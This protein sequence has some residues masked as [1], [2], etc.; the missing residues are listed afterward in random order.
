[1]N[2]IYKVKYYQLAMLR[3]QGYNTN[4]EDELNYFKHFEEKG[5]LEEFIE[6]NHVLSRRYISKLN[7]EPKYCYY[8]TEKVSKADVTA[9][10]KEVGN[11]KVIILISKSGITPVALDELIDLTSKSYRFVTFK[12]AELSFDLF[13][14]YLVPLHRKLSRTERKEL[15]K[16]SGISLDQ[17]PRITDQDPAVKRIDAQP[18]DVVKIFRRSHLAGSIVMNTV[19]YRLVIYQPPE[20]RA[21]LAEKIKV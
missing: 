20:E 12:F 15:V 11:T 14:N 18:G 17:L 21:E 4:E 7:C 3:N 16:K 6:A 1:M 8:V 13:K 19:A 9:M 2:E 5:M 10:K